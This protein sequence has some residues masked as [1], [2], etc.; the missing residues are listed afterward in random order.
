MRCGP[1]GSHLTK[2]FL[3]CR[4]F[5][6]FVGFCLS[7]LGWG[8]RGCFGRFRVRWGTWGPTSP[9]PSLIF[10]FPGFLCSCW[11][12]QLSCFSS[13]CFCLFWV[14]VVFLLSAQKPR[15]Q[16]SLFF[17][18]VH[19]LL[20]VHCLNIIAKNFL[21]ILLWLSYSLET[22]FTISICL[23]HIFH[24]SWLP[25]LYLHMVLVSFCFK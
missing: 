15:H 7:F 19:G 12:Q 5:G 22:P 3:F 4:C 16:L 6:C 20:L 10:Y 2:P 14:G 8:G 18:Q 1:K 23:Q 21:S 13:H 24:K 25:S 17:F 9:N 11:F